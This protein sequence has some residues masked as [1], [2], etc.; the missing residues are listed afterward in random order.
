MSVIGLSEIFGCCSLTDRAH[1]LSFTDLATG[2]GEVWKIHLL[3]SAKAAHFLTGVPGIEKMLLFN[4]IWAISFT[5]QILQRF[6]GR[7]P[8]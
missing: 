1:F 2:V 3:V 5:F 4:L 8:L 7:F 6:I